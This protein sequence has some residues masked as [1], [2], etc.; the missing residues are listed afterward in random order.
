[1]KKV[2]I[3]DL[4]AHLSSHLREVKQGEVLLVME[5]TTPV[6]QVVPAGPPSGI[7]IRPALRP[8]S[9]AKKRLRRLDPLDLPVSS[10]ALVL[11]DRNK[12]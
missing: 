6:A 1:M 12:R 2:G 5:R 3:A 11:E 9:E 8:F 10:L 4:K 7:V